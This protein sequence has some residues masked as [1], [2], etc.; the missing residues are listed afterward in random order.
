MKVYTVT[1]QYAGDV[2][3]VFSTLDKANSFA[4]SNDTGSLLVLEVELDHEGW[5]VA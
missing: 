3:A 5:T 4:D 1:E 2:L